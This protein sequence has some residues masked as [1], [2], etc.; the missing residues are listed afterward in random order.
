MTMPEGE[1][2]AREK[3]L[4]HGALHRAQRQ[5]LLHVAVGQRVVEPVERLEQSR[6]AARPLAALL[7]DLDRRRDVVR[8]EQ[9]AAQCLELR[10]VVLAVTAGRT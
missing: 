5:R 3:D 2:E 4:L 9:R 10:Q 8:L 7:R 1:L 6:C